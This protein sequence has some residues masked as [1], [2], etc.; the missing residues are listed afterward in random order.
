M[1]LVPSDITSVSLDTDEMVGCVSMGL[2]D[3]RRCLK[4]GR[5]ALRM[6]TDKPSE[7]A[8]AQTF[9]EGGA[10]DAAPPKRFFRAVPVAIAAGAGDGATAP[11]G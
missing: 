5:W 8:R 9:E 2:F 11:W 10:G 6:F 7:A 1:G 4:S 3:S